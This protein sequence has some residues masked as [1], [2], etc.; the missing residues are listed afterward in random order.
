MQEAPHGA[1]DNLLLAIRALL[2]ARNEQEQK[3]GQYVLDNPEDVLYLAISE[4][5]NAAQ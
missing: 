2:P 1:R 3:V 4:L 5:A